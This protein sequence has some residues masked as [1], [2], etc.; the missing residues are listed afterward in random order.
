MDL[1]ESIELAKLIMAICEIGLR[2]TLDIS[3]S[4]SRHC[5]SRRSQG[6]PIDAQDRVPRELAS[7][8]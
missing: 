6:P 1:Q 4:T 8:H 2:C 5:I 3:S 7:P